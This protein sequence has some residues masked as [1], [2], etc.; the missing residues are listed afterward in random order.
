M[1][2]IACSALYALWNSNAENSTDRVQYAVCR[3]NANRMKSKDLNA[4]DNRTLLPHVTTKWND[5][6]ILAS[7]STDQSTVSTAYRSLWK[8][9][10]WL[11]ATV[12]QFLFLLNTQN[13]L[14]GFFFYSNERIKKITYFDAYF[15]KNPLVFI[16]SYWPWACRLR[17]LPRSDFFTMLLLRFIFFGS[18]PGVGLDRRDF[19]F[20]HKTI[21]KFGNFNWRP[22]KQTLHESEC[23]RDGRIM[24]M[25]KSHESQRKIVFFF[26][27]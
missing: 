10:F 15:C 21:R 14:F 9:T 20:K 1:L 13:I 3:C 11:K 2:S 16:L 18:P 6:R 12:T 24:V 17:V 25:H 5:D 7:S 26:F 8:N 23:S 22:W 27:F 4:D 19:R